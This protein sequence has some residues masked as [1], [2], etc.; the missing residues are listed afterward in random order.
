[1]KFNI[2]YT[3]SDIAKVPKKDINVFTTFACGGGSTMGYKLNG[4]HVKWVNDIDPEMAKIYQK[5][6]HPENYYLCD[7]RDLKNQIPPGLVG[8]VDILDGSPPCSSFSMAGNREKDWGKKKV[9]KE[10]QAEQV[11][12]DLFFR[13]LDFAD[14]LKPKVIIAENVKGMLAGKAKVYTKNVMKRFDQ[15]GYNVQLFLLNSASMGVPQKRERIFFIASRKELNL[16]KL[17]MDFNEKPITFGQI[18]SAHGKEPTEHTKNVLKYYRKGDSDLGVINLRINKKN[19]QFT[20]KI[21][22]DDQVSN[23]VT[24]TGND[25]R[26]FDKL[27]CSDEDYTKRQSFPIDYDYMDLSAKYVTGMSVPPIMM[28]QIV[29]KLLEQWNLKNKRDLY[30][31]PK[32]NNI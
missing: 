6:H 22:A 14:Y 9:F 18:R 12:D 29:S 16:P 32:W 2:N 1:M 23:T 17:K 28:A 15:I 20:Q 24:S 13:F 27:E 31:N 4:L 3:L 19:T 11:L 7:I 21:L 30:F 26:A 10:G 25:Y 8:N 5:N